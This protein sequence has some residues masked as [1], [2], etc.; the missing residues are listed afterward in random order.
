MSYTSKIVY[1]GIKEKL[2]DL[3]IE[4]KDKINFK[5]FQKLKLL[6]EMK[7]VEKS[8]DYK[9]KGNII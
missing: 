6:N 8:I 2:I 1:K 5:D 4:N 9:K 3:R 7:E